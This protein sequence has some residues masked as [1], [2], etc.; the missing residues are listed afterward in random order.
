[1]LACSV[2]SYGG[3]S[4]GTFAP[5]PL[6][7]RAVLYK[8]AVLAVVFCITVALGNTSLRY[9]PVSFN[10]AIGATTPAFTALLTFLMA[11][12]RE[13]K[14]VYIALIPVVVGIILASGAEPSFHLLGFITAVSATAARAFKSGKERHKYMLLLECF[15]RIYLSL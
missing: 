13:A 3:A 12:Q 15:L 5:Q 4:A 14:E 6:K 10:Q 9:I 8:V 1:M 2:M 7:S 11:H